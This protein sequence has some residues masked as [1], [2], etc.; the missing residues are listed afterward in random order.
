VAFRR[1]VSPLSL[2]PSSPKDFA[3]WLDLTMEAQRNLDTSE[4]IWPTSYKILIHRPGNV[5]NKVRF[6]T[7]IN[8]LHIWHHGALIGESQNKVIQVQH[9]NP[10]ITLL[11]LE[12]VEC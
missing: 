1:N 5:L 2:V 7:S 10:G 3:G 9:V 6:K 11:V 12:G 4:T 8:L